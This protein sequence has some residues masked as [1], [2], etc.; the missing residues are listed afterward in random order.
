MPRS[1]A[2]SWRAV[3]V[4]GQKTRGREGGE[5]MDDFIDRLFGFLMDHETPVRIV[6]S[7]IGSVLGVLLAFNVLIPLIVQR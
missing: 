6:S 7:V 5:S 1:S 2:S 4:H 3:W